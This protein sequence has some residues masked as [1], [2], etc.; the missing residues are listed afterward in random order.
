MWKENE[1]NENDYKKICIDN[2]LEY[3]RSIS[4]MLY[5]KNIL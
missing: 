2:D 1:C 4:N 5:I 3:K